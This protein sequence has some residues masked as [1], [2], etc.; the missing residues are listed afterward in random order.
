[1]SRRHPDM[2]PEATRTMALISKPC[3][4]RDFRKRHFGTRQQLHGPLDPP[5]DQVIVRRHPDRLLERTNKVADRQVRELRQSTDTDPLID[6]VVDVLAQPTHDPWR[7]SAANI[8]GRAR[9]VRGIRPVEKL[10]AFPELDIAFS[11][12]SV[13]PFRGMVACLFA[14]CS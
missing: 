11:N 13:R 8:R 2:L 12:E 6:I 10:P 7:Q 9:R 14:R 1:M 3:G 5:S 4:K